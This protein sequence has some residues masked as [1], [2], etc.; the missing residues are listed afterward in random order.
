MCDKKAC[1]KDRQSSCPFASTEQSEMAWNTGC[2][3]GQ[4]EIISM[5]VHHGKTWA[6]HDNPKK[7]CAGAIADLRERGLPHKVE[8]KELLT[9]GSPWHLFSEPL[10]PR[11]RHLP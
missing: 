6:C 2:L 1:F 7:P 8:D 11:P 4:H 9:E 10:P 3:P 5:R